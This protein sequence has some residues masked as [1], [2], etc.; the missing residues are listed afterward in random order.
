MTCRCGSCIEESCQSSERGESLC[1]DSLEEDMDGSDI[2]WIFNHLDVLLINARIKLDLNW[3]QHGKSIVLSIYLF[4]LKTQADS[5]RVIDAFSIVQ[6]SVEWYL[7][8]F[9]GRPPTVPA[10]NTVLSYSDFF[11][12]HS[13]PLIHYDEIIFMR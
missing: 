10:T 12:W 1:R 9:F 7:K 13:K 5:S 6:C 2:D 8:Y 11:K 4:R 3:C